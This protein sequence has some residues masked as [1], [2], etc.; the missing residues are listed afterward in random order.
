VIEERGVR[1]YTASAKD[2]ALVDVPELRYIAVDG[3]G[4]PNT[5]PESA[6]AV[7]ALHAVAYALKFECRNTLG[8]DLTVGPLEGLWHAADMSAYV[9]RDKGARDWTMMISQPDVDP[10]SNQ[11]VATEG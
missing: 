10:A 7:E 6:D 2:F 8:R 9:T 4:D 1:R 3:H 5:A 11:V